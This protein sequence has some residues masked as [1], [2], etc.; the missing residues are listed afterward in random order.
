MMDALAVA[1]RPLHS[2]WRL[3]SHQIILLAMMI[4]GLLYFLLYQYF[5][6]YGILIAFK[7]FK[8]KKGILGSPWAKPLFK[9][10]AMFFQSP[11][12]LQVLKNTVVISFLKIIA[13]TVA[14]LGLA[15]LL[16][17][18]KV[19]W[20]KKGVQTITYLPHFLSWV[21]IFGVLYA[22][23]SESSGLINVMRRAGGKNSIPLL[24]NDQIFRILLIVSD[25][26]KDAGWGAII[27]LAA[28][29]GIDPGLY[30]AAQ[31][32]GA[33]RIQRIRHVT[34]ACI[35]PTIIIMIILRMGSVLDAGFDQIY[36]LYNSQVYSTSDIID[37]WVYRTGLEQMNYSVA[38][39]VGL[40]KSVLSM[41]LVVSVN[42][43]ARKWEESLW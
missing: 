32:D 11:Y 34:L 43:L 27:Y 33:N 20:F 1:N 13:N 38:T 41:I 16:S 21:I 14:S 15:V 36:I 24:T 31:I 2:K 29:A 18:V 19:K 35:R 12:C 3:K 23:C 22:L 7:E 39:A 9:N 40:F 30:E 28:I 17:E 42:A 25:V 6:M 8:I 26:W 37:T 10:F 5:P 4:P